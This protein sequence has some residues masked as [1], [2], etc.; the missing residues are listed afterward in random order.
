VDNRPN[1]RQSDESDNPYGEGRGRFWRVVSVRNI[2]K[3]FHN[4][5]YV[6]VAVIKES[7]VG[8]SK[9]WLVSFPDHESLTDQPVSITI[10]RETYYSSCGVQLK[11]DCFILRVA[12]RCCFSS[13]RSPH[14]LLPTS[15]WHSF[16]RFFYFK[17]LHT[18][19]AFCERAKISQF[20]SISMMICRWLGFLFPYIAIRLIFDHFLRFGACL[21]PLHLQN[22]G[23]LIISFCWEL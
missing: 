2:N 8:F 9:S 6:V 17:P 11:Q 22:H 1:I 3:G 19:Y 18:S 21:R 4:Q 14:W 10:C 20:I 15:A 16:F 13:F 12:S 23:Y 5:S 7:S